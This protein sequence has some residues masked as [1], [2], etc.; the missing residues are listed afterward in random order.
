MSVNDL[1]IVLTT[2]D[3]HN[4]LGSLYIIKRINNKKIKIILND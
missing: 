3:L 4:L 2:E 1:E